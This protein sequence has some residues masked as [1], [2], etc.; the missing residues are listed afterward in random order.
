MKE[1]LHCANGKDETRVRRAFHWVVAFRDFPAGSYQTI[2]GDSM[3]KEALTLFTK[4]RAEFYYNGVRRADRVPGVLSTE[5]DID[6]EGGE[7][8]LKYVEPTSRICIPSKINRGKLPVV[9]KVVLVANST[10]ELEGKYLVCVG[11]LSV[12]GKL[13]GEMTTFQTT[14]PTSATPSQDCILLKFLS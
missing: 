5:H 4:G 3:V 14:K 9:E 1:T 6:W 2:D 11:S 12:N 13:F 8:L 7:F 10:Y